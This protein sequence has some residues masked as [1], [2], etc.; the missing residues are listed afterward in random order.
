MPRLPAGEDRKVKRNCRPVRGAVSRSTTPSGVVSPD[1]SAPRGWRRSRALGSGRRRIAF[2]LPR[3]RSQAGCASPGT[4]D[5][6]REVCS[7]A[8]SRLP[9]LVRLTPSSWP[10]AQRTIR[11]ELPIRPP[12]RS[13]LGL[14][15][16]AKISPIKKYS[17]LAKPV[18]II[19]VTAISVFCQSDPGPTTSRVKRPIMGG[20]RSAPPVGQRPYFDM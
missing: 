19:D 6:R 3:R 7:P 9:R 5:L 16:R 17:N 15:V 18:R 1:H 13:L 4:G 8:R 20:Y 11:P 10:R 14:R 12:L 2:F